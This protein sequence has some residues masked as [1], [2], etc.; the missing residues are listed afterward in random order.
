L[1]VAGGF[2]LRP[3]LLLERR[4]SLCVWGGRG[5]GRELRPVERTPRRR[6]TLLSRV[7][8]LPPCKFTSDE[9]SRALVRAS[10][11]AERR[12]CGF[13]SG[14]AGATADRRRRGSGLVAGARR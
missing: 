2:A 7:L 13:A 3:V 5:K 14:A 11:I 10:S 12:G 6:R 1:S 8:V 9:L 4:C